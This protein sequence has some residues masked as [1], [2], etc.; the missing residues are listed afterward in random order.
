MNTTVQTKINLDS[1]VD[2][3]AGQS[4]LQIDS[5]SGKRETLTYDQLKARVNALV[6]RLHNCG[7]KENHKI[8]IQAKN[9]LEWV[10]LDLAC[11]KIGAKLVA[12]PSDFNGISIQD[13]H[14]DLF[15][16]DISYDYHVNIKCPKLAITNE[17]LG[18]SALVLT[19]LDQPT[20]S[21]DILTYTFSSGTSGY[22]K[23]LLI[24]KTGTENSAT[25]FISDFNL[26]SQDSTIIFMPLSNFQQRMLIYGCLY[27]G[28]S[29]F[30]V[31]FGTIF[32]ALVEH[33]PTFLI[34]PP[35]LYEQL[36]KIYKPSSNNGE[37]LRK[38]LGGNTRFLIVGMAPISTKIIADFNAAG[39]R[40]LEVYGVTETGM[41]AW[42]LLEDNTIGTVGRPIFNDVLLSE[43]NE[44]L[45]KRDNPLSIGYFLDPLAESAN[46]FQADGVIATGDLG[47]FDEHG[48][49]VLVGRKKDIII[50]SGG[51]KFHPSQIEK[52]VEEI[53]G[54]EK[55][56]VLQNRHEPTQLVAIVKIAT[57]EVLGNTLDLDERIQNLNNNLPH[58]MR[59][60]KHIITDVSFNAESGFLTRNLKVNRAFVH[61]Y[62]LGEQDTTKEVQS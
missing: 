22:L 29:L 34:A 45:V 42:N 40:L 49:L 59:I 14:I 6:V 52:L 21:N 18:L 55:A 16:Y 38:G 37:S 32:R 30:F 33:S 24:S 2:N 8:G 41:I 57:T 51:K 20:H 17:W 53:A 13:I 28:V 43:S 46:T 35:A 50:T 10:E 60:N 36:G 48:K 58:H 4:V 39:V 56:V 5:V 23:G 15:V 47:R 44:I 61:D 27:K 62:F 1:L 12:I 7:I 54:V 25:K 31:D 19:S 11:L 26:T 3:L 9:C